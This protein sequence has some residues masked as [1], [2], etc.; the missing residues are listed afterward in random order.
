MSLR[1]DHEDEIAIL[2]LD[3]ESVHNSLNL[4]LV[5]RF[6]ESVEELSN[7]PATRAL[8]VTGTGQA[9]FS[10]GADM[11]FMGGL[12]EEDLGRFLA[13]VRRL[14]RTLAATRV[15]TIALV[16]GYAHGG[17]AEIA[18]CCDLRLGCEATS[19]RFPGV[20]YGMAVGSWHLAAVVG[21]P[22]AKELMFTGCEVDAETSLEIG[23]LNQ[24][25]PSGEL[26]EF[27][28]EMARQISRNPPEA[29]SAIKRLLDQGVGT[30][31]QQRFYRE[32]YSNRERNAG[33]T[34][35]AAF[36]KYSLSPRKTEPD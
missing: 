21:L 15:P 24:L 18:C 31:L 19:F 27:G 1:I 23:L 2:S 29:V 25:V 5:E 9:A 17:G 32:L 14:F 6:I 3:R 26:Q 35:Q 7:D 16:N 4:D 11:R 12:S 8:L 30:P 36:R 34:A 33:R 10:A 13:R 20:V 22:K 28:F